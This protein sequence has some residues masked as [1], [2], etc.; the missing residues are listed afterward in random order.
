MIRLTI[1]L[2]GLQ[3]TKI[4]EL[5]NSLRFLGFVQFR[6]FYTQTTYH[7]PRHIPAEFFLLFFFFL[8][9]FLFFYLDLLY[10]VVIFDPGTNACA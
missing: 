8:S 10:E 1:T 2:C 3:G 9:F 6:E 5:T 7:H 4:Q